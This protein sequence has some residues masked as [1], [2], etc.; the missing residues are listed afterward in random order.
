MEILAL[1]MSEEDV[2]HLWCS[3][4]IL[5]SALFP[6]LIDLGAEGDHRVSQSLL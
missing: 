4:L 2:K 3:G 6:V 5:W 1:G